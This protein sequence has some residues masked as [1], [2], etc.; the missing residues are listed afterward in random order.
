MNPCLFMP[1]YCAFMHDFTQTLRIY[2][3]SIWNGRA[4]NLAHFTDLHWQK[5]AIEMQQCFVAT[6][7]KENVWGGMEIDLEIEFF[8][9]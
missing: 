7:V 2:C 3:P 1:R 9:Y 4:I 8:K 6:I 5:D